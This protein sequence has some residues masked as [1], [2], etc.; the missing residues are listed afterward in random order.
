MSAR[1]DQIGKTYSSTRAADPRIA[2][3][4]SDLCDVS[5]GS[6]LIDIGAGTGNYSCALAELG[7]EVHAVEPSAVMRAQAKQHPDLYWYGAI[8]EDLPFE[9]DRFDAA[10]MTLCIHH[11][12]DWRKGITEAIRVTNNESLVLFAFDIEFQ[13]NFWLFDYFPQFKDMDKVLGPSI[14]QLRDYVE[15]ELNMPFYQ[16]PFPLPKDLQDHFAVADWAKPENYLKAEYRSGISTFHKLDA[17]NLHNGLQALESDLKDGSW[18]KK[19]GSLLELEEY[20]QGYL[21]LRIN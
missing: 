16:E 18:M 20:D 7:F 8:A 15:G 19:Y 21:F 17:H 11:F 13:I 4:L 1:Y 3:R 6:S 9:N 12:Q 2:T 10:V 5:K 14:H